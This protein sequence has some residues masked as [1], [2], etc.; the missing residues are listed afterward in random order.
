MPLP[1][2]TFESLHGILRTL[3]EKMM[4]LC[5]KMTA[6]ASAIA[7]IGALLYISYR[8]W[9]SIA[10]AEPI[11][12]F[13]LLRPFALCICI[14]LFKPL[15]LDGIGGIM[16]PVVNGTHQI[17]TGQTFDMNEHRRAKDQLEKENMMRSPETAYIV[18]DEE[19]DRQIAELGMSPDDFNTMQNMYEDRIGFGFRSLVVEAFR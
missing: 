19:F 15:V 1:L 8:V 13:P 14:V 9:Q 7:C 17:L 11:D 2:V 16:T 4:P 12:V 5:G 6:I 18:D 10:R 3:F